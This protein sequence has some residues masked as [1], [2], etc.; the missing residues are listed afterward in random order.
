M[1]NYVD[2][3]VDRN[4]QVDGFLK[5]VSRDTDRAI[6]V[7]DAPSE[8][9]KTWLIQKM[10][11]HC[12]TNNIPV[13][14]I[15]FRDRREYDYLSLV[16]FTRDQIGGNYFNQL[17][18]VINTFTGVNVSLTTMGG[19]N[20]G[21]SVA[22]VDG[23]VAVEGDIAGR[24]LIKDNK[25][26][27]QA[28]SDMARRAAEIQI[29]DAFFQCLNQVTAANPAAVFLFDSYEKITKE[30][31][32][33]L[34]DYLLFRIRE[35]LV[36]NVLVMIAGQKV[37]AIDPE[38]KPF[39]AKTGLTPFTQEDIQE[40]II[41]RRQIAGLD[42]ETIFKTSGGFPGLLAKMADVAAIET[43]GDDDWL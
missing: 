21:V 19:G 33:W 27:I 7:I 31:E 18:A 17:T 16:R 13:M 6:M 23:D 40:Y 1:P 35:G 4:K 24:D 37:P 28:D 11:H 38:L 20:S 43:G 42:I 30:A 3:F 22:H 5:M 25:F 12:E 39:V 34:L 8:M 36:S 32:R 26:F 41:E 9:G 14:H 2:W 29:N 10:R 15:D